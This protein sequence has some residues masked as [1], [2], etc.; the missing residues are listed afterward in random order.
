MSPFPFSLS[1]QPVDLLVISGVGGN[2]C[3]RR[4]QVLRSGE[5]GELAEAD[6]EEEFGE[7]REAGQVVACALRTLMKRHVRKSV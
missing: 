7:L 5:E 6:A 4:S 3:P 2:V 1:S